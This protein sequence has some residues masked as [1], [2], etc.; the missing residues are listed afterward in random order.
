MVAVAAYVLFKGLRARN[1][2]RPFL[3]ALALFLLCF[4]GL[5]ISFFPYLVPTSVTVWE[6]AAPETSLVFLLAG[7]AVLIPIILAY[8]VYSYWVFRGKVDT[9]GGYH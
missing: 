8:T 4:V 7:A 6:A 1:E 9:A 3:A 2:L 5:L